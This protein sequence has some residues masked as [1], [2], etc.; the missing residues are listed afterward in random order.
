MNTVK[1]FDFD[2]ELTQ[3]QRKVREATEGCIDVHEMQNFKDPVRLG[4]N[5]AS[6]GTVSP[7]ETVAFAQKMVEVAEMVRNFKYNGYYIEWC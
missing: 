6:I 2:Q 4:V 1:A 7:E 5:W 3:L